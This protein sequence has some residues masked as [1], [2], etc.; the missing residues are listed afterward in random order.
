MVFAFGEQQIPEY[1]AENRG[2]F[3]ISFYGASAADYVP[4]PEWKT[5]DV[6]LG[7]ITVPKNKTTYFCKAFP[8]PGGGGEIKSRR[9]GKNGEKYHVVRYEPLVSTD[10]PEMVHHLVVWWCRD[11]PKK[12][13][14]TNVCEDFPEPCFSYYAAWAIGGGAF[15]LPDD[16]GLPMGA[17]EG[18]L[19]WGVLQI[20]YDNPAELEGVRDNSG[21]RFYYTNQLRKY[22]AGILA[23]GPIVDYISIPPNKENYLVETRC[24]KECIENKLEDKEDNI[25]IFGVFQHMHLLGSELITDV[26]HGFGKQEELFAL[27]YYNF[28]FQ[29]TYRIPEVT[30]GWG[31]EIHVRCYYNSIGRSNS[32][33]GG[34]STQEEM[35]F[36]YLYY[37]P[38]RNYF[39]QCFVELENPKI[40]Q[41]ELPYYIGA[42][43]KT[44]AALSTIAIISFV[45]M[46]VM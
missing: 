13:L 45:L 4:D 3:Q 27:R 5:L 28:D 34:L 24:P 21:L 39:S 38:V 18:S 16:A 44:G 12:W 29:N 8:T 2:T 41:C 9:D 43:A 23:A 22:D 10:R 37:Y 19:K 6:T 32:T 35:C 11:Y 42:A 46:F 7:P 15:N 33:L 14:E 36:S 26:S 1:H 30:I 40:A 31:D 17:G 25:K 20:H